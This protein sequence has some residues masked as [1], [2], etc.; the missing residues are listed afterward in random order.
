MISWHLYVFEKF[1][2]IPSTCWMLCV[3]NVSFSPH[4]NHMYVP[5]KW[6]VWAALDY[7][8]V[9][10]WSHSKRVLDKPWFHSNIVIY[11]ANWGKSFFLSFIL[12]PQRPKHDIHHDFYDFFFYTVTNDKITE[13]RQLS[14]LKNKDTRK[15]NN[16]IDNKLEYWGMMFSVPVVR[17]SPVG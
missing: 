6:Q 1:V 14:K 12:Q 9:N 13:R 2:S 7:Y 16:P 4:I 3:V 5:N 10:R 17:T 8:S 15:N 11:T